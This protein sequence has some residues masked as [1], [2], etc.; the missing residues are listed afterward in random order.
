MAHL[1]NVSQVSTIYY[2]P[3]Q[4]LCPV[5]HG[6]LKRDHIVWHKELTFS[7]V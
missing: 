2:R 5:C 1:T 4:T 7:T 3:E 6:R